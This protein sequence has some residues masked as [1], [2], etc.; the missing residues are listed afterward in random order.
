MNEW[1]GKPKKKRYVIWSFMLVPFIILAILAVW[2]YVSDCG[3]QEGFTG[4][5]MAYCRVRDQIEI[6]VTVY[7]ENHNQSLPILSGTYTN[8]NFSDCHVVNMSA[9]L[10]ANGGW[11][12]QAP[13]G[14]NL[15]ASGNDN[16]GGNSSLGCKNG[17][18][19]I[20]IVN[21]YGIVYS[22]CAGAKC[23]TNNS[24]YQGVWP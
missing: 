15:S 22:Y 23:K 11:L 13:S 10:T 5:E 6:A 12:R 3:G 24:D 4:N 18:S 7:A 17:S 16:C 9:L 14:L 21:T 20:W 2:F 8:A 19:Y 1:Q